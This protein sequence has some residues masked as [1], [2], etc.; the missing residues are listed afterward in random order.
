MHSKE[1]EGARLWDYEPTGSGKRKS[2]SHV[3]GPQEYKDNLSHI[4]AHSEK[5]EKRD[6]RFLIFT[7]LH[8]SLS[9]PVR[10]E[11][12]AQGNAQCAKGEGEGEGWGEGDGPAAKRPKRN[13]GPQPVNNN[14]G[15]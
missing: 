1:R 9:A 6:V 11:E 4:L 15:P 7:S 3:F 2:F 14:D 10:W 8:A 12:I 13:D 5:V